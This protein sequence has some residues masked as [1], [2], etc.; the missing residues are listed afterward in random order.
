MV[1]SLMVVLFPPVLLSQEGKVGMGVSTPDVSQPAT[2]SSSSSSTS[3]PFQV[4]MLFKFLDQWRSITSNR[5][6][7]N[8]VRGHHLQLRSCPPFVSI[9]NNIV[10]VLYFIL[11][12]ISSTLT[13]A[14]GRNNKLVAVL[15]IDTLFPC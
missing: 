9:F 1:R 8:M 5:F 6:V 4:G 13:H 11:V 12:V 10:C 2:S 15:F 3:A 7:L 14:Y